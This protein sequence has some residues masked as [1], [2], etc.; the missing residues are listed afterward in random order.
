MLPDKA[1]ILTEHVRLKLA[2]YMDRSPQDIAYLVDEKNSYPTT[3]KIGNKTYSIKMRNPIV[4]S[5]KRN[6]LLW[7]FDLRTDFWED[8]R[9]RKMNKTF[10][11]FDYYV[12]LGLI[13]GN[14]KKIFVVP[15]N[16]TPKS[17]VRISVDGNSKYKEYEI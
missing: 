15:E 1:K 9:T 8:G 11:G 10:S 16:K 14:P 13:D 5:K 3:L 4:Q 6:I 12:L 17:H 7:D 2:E